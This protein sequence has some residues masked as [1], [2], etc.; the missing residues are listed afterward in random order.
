MEEKVILFLQG[1]AERQRGR[2]DQLQ[3]PVPKRDEF[4]LKQV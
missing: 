4:R 2:A 1:V 3:P